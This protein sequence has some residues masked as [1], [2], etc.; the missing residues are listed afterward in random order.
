M[1][2][3]LLGHAVYCSQNPTHEKKNIEAVIVAVSCTGDKWE[4]LVK[5]LNFDAGKVWARSLN[6]LRFK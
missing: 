6:D 3:S 5:L 4:F 2:T 1:E